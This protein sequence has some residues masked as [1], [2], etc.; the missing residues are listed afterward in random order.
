MCLFRDCRR[1]E[2]EGS[3]RFFYEPEE[4]R[5]YLQGLGKL[6]VS[7]FTQKLWCEFYRS[8]RESPVKKPKDKYHKKINNF[9]RDLSL[10]KRIEVLDLKDAGYYIE[11]LR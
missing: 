8:T 2:I 7:V 9:W 4:T 11:K 6:L 10:A 5:F 3:E 1:L